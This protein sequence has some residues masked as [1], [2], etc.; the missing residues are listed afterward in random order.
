MEWCFSERYRNGD[1]LRTTVFFLYSP[2]STFSSL[3]LSIPVLFI[4]LGFI[5]LYRLF[6]LLRLVVPFSLPR[7][8]EL[9]AHGL[10]GV[11]SQRTETWEGDPWMSGTAKFN[12]RTLKWC[13]EHEVNRRRIITICIWYAASSPFFRQEL[14]P[15]CLSHAERLWSLSS[16]LPN[17]CRGLFLCR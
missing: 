10:R 16:F 17:E 9:W 8:A 1:D 2:P 12:I 11:R 3:F 4:L 15:F 5:V 7:P 13:S 6:H 14:W